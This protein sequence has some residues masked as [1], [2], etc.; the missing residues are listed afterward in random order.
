MLE[1]DA[2]YIHTT[3]MSISGKIEAQNKRRISKDF[4]KLSMAEA[5]ALFVLKDGTAR[6]MTQIARGLGVAVSTA[7]TTIDRLVRKNLAV[8]HVGSEDRR[9]W[10]ITITPR[11]KRLVKEMNK[12]AIEGTKKFLECLSKSEIS[13][14]KDILEKI[15][16]NLNPGS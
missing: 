5:K 2:G 10:L 1:D 11:A 9:Q 13:F 4:E 14:L 12:S 3:L 7:T 6:N 16:N 15:N 8:R